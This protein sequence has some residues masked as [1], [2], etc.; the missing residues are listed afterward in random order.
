MH[1]EQGHH[2]HGQAEDQ[3]VVEEDRLAEEED[4]AEEEVGDK[5]VYFYTC[6][7]CQTPL[8]NLPYIVKGQYSCRDCFN[9][10]V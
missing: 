8:Y 5:A 1:A 7:Q 4:H 10:L 6:W 9:N 3:L 2:H